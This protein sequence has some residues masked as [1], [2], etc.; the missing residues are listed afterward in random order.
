[1]NRGIKSFRTPSNRQIKHYA[2]ALERRVA[3]LEQALK[4]VVKSEGSNL[5][6]GRYSLIIPDDPRLLPQP[7]EVLK[8]THSK[9]NAATTLV[10]EIDE[11]VKKQIDAFQAE[12]QAQQKPAEQASVIIDPA[13]QIVLT[14]GGGAEILTKVPEA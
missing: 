14:D 4:H 13:S 12:M 5:V 10:L 11:D 1:M 7:Y 6:P 9:E 8:I 2:A 3:A